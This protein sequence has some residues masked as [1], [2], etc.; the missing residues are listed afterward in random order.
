MVTLLV[1]SLVAFQSCLG[2]RM[3]R[4]STDLCGSKQGLYL[5]LWLQTNKQYLLWGVGS[6]NSL[7]FGLL[8]A[9]RYGPACLEVGLSNYLDLGL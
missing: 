9:P 6:R 7:C 4:A 8:G 1:Q 5:P 3:S 2:E